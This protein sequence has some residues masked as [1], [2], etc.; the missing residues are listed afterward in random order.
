MNVK[1]I[2]YGR[3]K[4]QTPD[5]ITATKAQISGVIK[6]MNMRTPEPV[7]QQPTAFDMAQKVWNMRHL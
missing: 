6:Q 3:I 2:R 4:R 7:V 1:A 5:K